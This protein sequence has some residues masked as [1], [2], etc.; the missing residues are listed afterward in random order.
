M[1]NHLI[2]KHII[3][4][5]LIKTIIIVFIFCGL[6]IGLKILDN[7]T[8]YITEFASKITSLVIK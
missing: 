8:G 7:Q 1:Q 4:K 3:T 2:N 6:L 5:D